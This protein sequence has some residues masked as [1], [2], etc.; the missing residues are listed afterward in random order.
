MVKL[1]GLKLDDRHPK[2]RQF[3]AN[4]A[5][6]VLF[7][8]NLLNYADRY[9]PAAV[10]TLFAEELHLTDF[11]TTLPNTGMIIVF[12]IFAV[13][14]GTISDNQLIDRRFVLCFA[15][16]LWSAATALAGLSTNLTQLIALRSLVG[17]GEA[18]YGTI[19]PP[20]LSD[21][22]PEHERNVVYGVSTTSIPNIYPLPPSTYTYPNPLPPIY[23]ST[24]SP[25][26]SV[27]H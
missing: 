17:V 25:S 11:E 3:G 4:H 22:F 2:I 21:F 9:V 20:I 5:L 15:I 23:R 13:I 7:A 8:I 19:A 27:Q 14:F 6:R 26:Q 24:T 12:M 10:K 18:A 1:V 16:I